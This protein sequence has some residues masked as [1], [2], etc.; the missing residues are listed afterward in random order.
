MKP[1]ETITTP[2]RAAA[3]LAHP[4]RPRILAHAREPI[5]ASEL[6]RRLDQPRQRLNYHVRQLAQH[7]LL[8][9]VGQQRRRNMVEQQYIASAQAYVLTPAVLGDAAPA[10]AG[11]QD[12]TSAAQ[13]IGLCARAQN[14][15][16]RLIETGH[17]AGIR[18]RTLSLQADVAF[19]TAEQRTTFMDEI[20]SAINDV[21]ARYHGKASGRVFR[22][23][24]GC[25]PISE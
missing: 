8:E 20:K 16:A 7:D 9:A 23:V 12:Q 4:L 14:D 22:L 5:S 17:A 21:A 1:V 24:F 10:G 13:L 19:D 18:V 6:A 3:I 2:R 11:N 15:V 25:Y